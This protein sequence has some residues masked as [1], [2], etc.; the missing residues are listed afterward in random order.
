[1]GLTYTVL[2]MD[3]FDWQYADKKKNERVTDLLNALKEKSNTVELEAS[4][5]RHVAIEMDKL[6]PLKKEVGSLLLHN[7]DCVH[8]WVDIEPWN[9]KILKEEDLHE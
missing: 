7:S 5:Y 9:K 8:Y 4:W 2:L 3:E 1:M 6:S